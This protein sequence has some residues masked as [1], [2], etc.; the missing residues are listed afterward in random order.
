M[1]TAPQPDDDGAPVRYRGMDAF[2]PTIR[3]WYVFKRRGG[4]ACRCG[5]PLWSHRGSNEPGCS[6]LGTCECTEYTAP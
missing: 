3:G 5:H 6:W 4:G 1:A 2:A